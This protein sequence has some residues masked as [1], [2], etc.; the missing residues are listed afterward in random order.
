VRTVRRWA[1]G[2]TTITVV[3]EPGFEFLVAQ[4]PEITAAVQ[5]QAWLAPYVAADGQLR[6]TTS[7]VVIDTGE[8]R[9][10]VDPWLAFDDPERSAPALRKRIER[11]LGA[12]ADAG[13]A[14]DDIS[15][16]VNTHIDGTGANTRPGANGHDVATFPNARYYFPRAEFEALDR[17]AR[18]GAE[19]L[20]ELRTRGAATGIDTPLVIDD[21]VSVLAAPGH[22]PGHMAVEVSSGDA[23]ALIIGHMFLHP[24]TLLDPSA[25]LFDEDPETN[26]RTRRSF[27]DRAVSERALLIGPLFA[28]P[29]GG[30]VER[31]EPG[32]QLRA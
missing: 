24:A 18:P 20:N 2:A 17:G 1:V 16:V 13:F 15:F 7:A 27:L 12:L 4:G 3:D 6:V 30:Y 14:L 31:G 22:T 25:G 8:H 9:V 10:L 11:L 19:V 28:P 5:A 21:A 32:W 29:G 26:L 23:T